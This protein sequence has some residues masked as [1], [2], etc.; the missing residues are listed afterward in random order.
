MN[1]PAVTTTHATAIMAVILA[2][3]EARAGAPW[4]VRPCLAWPGAKTE[5]APGRW[6]AQRTKG[7]TQTQ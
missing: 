4:V 3:V 2:V 7:T 1:R 5:M 6:A